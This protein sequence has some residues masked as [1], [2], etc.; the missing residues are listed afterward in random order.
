M[1]REQIALNRSQEDDIDALVAEGLKDWART[2]DAF[3]SPVLQLVNEVDTFD[4]FLARLPELQQ[5]LK[6]DEF[7]QQ[8]A[9][10]SFK[11]RALGDVNDG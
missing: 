8:L 9:L 11:A 1:N 7:V 5:S 4:E 6:P 2:G 3:T 10:L